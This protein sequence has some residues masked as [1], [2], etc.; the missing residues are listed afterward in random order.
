MKP[1]DNLPIECDIDEAPK[2]PLISKP[3]NF[4][5]LSEDERRENIR[6]RREIMQSM[7]LGVVDFLKQLFRLLVD[8]VPLGN[9]LQQ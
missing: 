4:K 9:N 3:K 6:M 7:E 2:L 5:H 8:A 1:T